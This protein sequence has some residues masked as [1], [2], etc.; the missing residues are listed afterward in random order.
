MGRIQIGFA[1]V[2]ETQ[3]SFGCDNRCRAAA[4]QSFALPPSVAV[5]VT[6]AGEERNA[7]RQALAR[8]LQQNNER[9]RERGDVAGPAGAWETR[10]SLRALHLR[11]VQVAEAIHFRRAQESKI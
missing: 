3:H 6:W 8:V 4:R 11:R 5:A 9:V 7:L 10:E 2:I 1:V